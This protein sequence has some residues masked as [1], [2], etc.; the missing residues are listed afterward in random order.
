MLIQM[1]ELHRKLRTVQERVDP[2]ETMCTVDHVD[3][4]K[5]FHKV[6]CQFI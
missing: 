2:R 1:P 4:G 6:T 3:N 5:E